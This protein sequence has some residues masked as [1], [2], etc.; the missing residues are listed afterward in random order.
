MVVVGTFLD[1]IIRG[2]E[3]LS[4]IEI[5]PLRRPGMRNVFLKTGHRVSWYMKEVLP[6]FLFGSVILFLC[7]LVRLTTTFNS[8]SRIFAKF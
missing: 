2:D 1:R 3:L 5:P 4:V 6:I 8:I 7:D